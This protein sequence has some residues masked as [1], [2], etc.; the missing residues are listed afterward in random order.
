[1]TKQNMLSFINKVRK[2]ILALGADL[3][4]LNRVTF[5]RRKAPIGLCLYNEKHKNG[6]II[7]FSNVLLTLDDE[8]IHET[9]AHELLHTIKN[10]IGHDKVFMKYAKKLNA[11]YG[12]NIGKYMSRHILNDEIKHKLYNY[13]VKCKDCGEPVGYIRKAEIVRELLSKNKKH[14]YYCPYCDSSHLEID[15]ESSRLSYSEMMR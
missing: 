7:E 12:L 4:P 8:S 13:V 6:C 3:A 2:D 11:I 5:H 1:M 10:S 9:V 14:G 15:F